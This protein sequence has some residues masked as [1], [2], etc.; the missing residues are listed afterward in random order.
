[1][2]SVILTFDEEKQSM[3]DN[4]LL[5]HIVRLPDGALR[6][7]VTVKAEEYNPEAI[8]LANEELVRRN[9][10]PGSEPGESREPEVDCLRC[11][12]NMVFAGKKQFHEGVRLGVLGGLGELLVN[13][14]NFDLWVCKD[15]G[16]VE[17][18]MEI[19]R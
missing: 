6:Q 12:S 14:E 17:F 13:R 3:K 18:F 16:H 5:D 10:E 19:K 1:L 7:M 9:L 4:E 15:C 8:E 11:K 2:R